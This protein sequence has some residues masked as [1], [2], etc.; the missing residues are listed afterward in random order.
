MNILTKTKTTQDAQFDLVLPLDGHIKSVIP[1]PG[2]D[3][4]LF[5]MDAGM[6]IALGRI[7]TDLTLAPPF[8]PI[9]GGAYFSDS[10][11]PGASG[12]AAITHIVM[13]N[14]KLWAFGLFFDFSDF[15]DHIAIIRYHLDGLV[16]DSFG[17]HGRVVVTFPA[18]K[19]R[20]DARQRTIIRSATKAPSAPPEV[21]PDGKMMFFFLDINEDNWDGRAVLVRLTAQGDLDT[22]FNGT[23]IAPV[24][25]AGRDLNPRGLLAQG[26][27]TIV[28]G[29][30][31]ARQNEPSLAVIGRY[32]SNG[33]LDE[34]FSGSGFITIG[35][36]DHYVTTLGS[37]AFDEQN[38]IIVTGTFYQPGAPEVPS[39]LFVARLLADGYPDPT[40]NGGNAL[41]VN[42]PFAVHSVNATTIQVFKQNAILIAATA[43]IDGQPRGTLIRLTSKGALDVDFSGGLG[44]HLAD[45]RSEYLTL[46]LTQY[47]GIVVGGYVN[48]EFGGLPAEYAWLRH[49]SEDGQRKAHPRQRVMPIR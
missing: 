17:D 43:D 45:R 2:Y 20:Y 21:L 29:T 19:K 44:Y 18:R 25:L 15:T 8:G 26:D 14:D 3:H 1:G 16:D 30:T 41:G 28:F 42:L 11:N 23:G 27:K 38:R 32:D 13:A 33:Q 22:G 12:F 37:F 7:N 39:R 35:D 4:W 10:F 47:P 9:P 46:G 49:F 24:Q 5:G 48:D 36:E 40:F 6:A 31:Q 34:S